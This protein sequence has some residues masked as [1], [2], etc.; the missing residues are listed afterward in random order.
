MRIY[1]RALTSL[2][3]AAAV[4]ASVQ[5]ETFVRWDRERVPSPE[6]LGLSTLVVP[7]ANAAA[8]RNA[9]A[10][11]YRLYLEVDASAVAGFIPPRA[12]VAGVVVKGAV[13]PARLRQVRQRLQ[14][15]GI[16]VLAL[17]ERAKWPHIRANWVT[18]NNEVLQV[19]GRSAQPWIENNAALL[20]ILRATASAPAP[21]LI[22][23]WT[24]ITVSERDEGPGID[25]YLVAIA[26]AGSFGGDLVLPLHER[27]QTDLLLGKP[28]ARAEWNQIR[29]YL[30]FYSWNLASAYEPIANIGVVTADPMQ[31]FEVMNLL[32]RHNLPFQRIAPAAL[33]L[34]APHPFRLL[35]VL[36]PPDAARLAFLEAFARQGGTVVLPGPPPDSRRDTAGLPRRSAEREGGLK[37]D[38]RVSYRFGEGRVVE[39]MKGIADPNAFALEM[40]QILGPDHRVIDIW[41]GITVLTAPHQELRGNTVLVTALNYAHD[42]LPVQLRVA[43]TFSLVQYESPEEPAALLPY[44]HRNGYTEFVVPALHIG[45]RVFLTRLP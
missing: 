27:F 17:E 12:G 28:Q 31:W 6:S 18:K 41:N 7:A 37:T 35:I 20:R 15:R 9:L 22:Y 8:I 33:P 25:D 13:S 38:E 11:G 19:T 44:Q 39:V 26:E 23:A 45:G 10:H 40:R 42:P 3:L 4:S 14:P 34:R 30:D 5:A 32:L 21:V 1:Q 36:D 16:R 2:L 29:R 24:P 43:G